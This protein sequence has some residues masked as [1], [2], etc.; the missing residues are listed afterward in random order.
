MYVSVAEAFDSGLIALVAE[1]LERG[2]DLVT[3][4]TPLEW[5]EEMV[6][7]PTGGTTL[8]DVRPIYLR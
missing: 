2:A 6:P 8:I 7:C 4:M 3:T 1:M 5:T